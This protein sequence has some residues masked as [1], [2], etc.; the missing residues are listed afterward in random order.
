MKTFKQTFLTAVLLATLVLS[1]GCGLL[2]VGGAVAGATYGTVKYVKNTLNVTQD[3]TLDRSWSAAN[4]ALAELHM[5]ITE[6]KKD[7]TSGRL[8]ARNA[9]D[10]PV[11]IELTWKT[12]RVT[13]IQITVGTFE[14]SDNRA[15]AE[16]LYNVMKSRM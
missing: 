9:K 6:S 8:E 14:S 12:E 15:E 3:V 1:Q 2:L 5:P 10:Q 11:I 16:H 4:S 7:G 13:A